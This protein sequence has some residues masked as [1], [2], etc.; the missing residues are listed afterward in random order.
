MGYTVKHSSGYYASSY[1]AYIISKKRGENLSIFPPHFKIGEKYE[2]ILHN[3]H[4]V[5]KAA[6]YHNYIYNYAYL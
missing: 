5:T 3:K 2:K 6:K 4:A 1:L